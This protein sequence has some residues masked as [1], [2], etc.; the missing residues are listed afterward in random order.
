MLSDH[1]L[2]QSCRNFECLIFLLH[3]L[4]FLLHYL[5]FLLH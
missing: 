1:F 3:Y 4:I 2:V 5:I